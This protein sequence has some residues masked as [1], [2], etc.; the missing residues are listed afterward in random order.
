[1]TRNYVQLISEIEP[2]AEVRV[3]EDKPCSNC[4]IKGS[5]M[6]ELVLVDPA[7]EFENETTKR[8]REC[9]NMGEVNIRA[10]GAVSLMMRYY[11]HFYEDFLV[12]LALDNAYPTDE[13][14]TLKLVK[15]WFRNN[16]ASEALGL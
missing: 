9:Q 12:E 4:G 10:V 11:G 16:P 8:L 7:D 1:M 14:N 2:I 5:H 15:Q 13:E 3:Y 6:M